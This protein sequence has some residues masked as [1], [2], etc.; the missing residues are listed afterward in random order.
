MVGG[1]SSTGLLLGGLKASSW[2]LGDHRDTG[3]RNPGRVRVRC[4]LL[5]V[6]FY[7]GYVLGLFAWP[8]QEY[9]HRP[10]TATHHTP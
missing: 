8:Q 4:A 7:L 3:G 10:A 1:S 9:M 2:G 5:V 6:F